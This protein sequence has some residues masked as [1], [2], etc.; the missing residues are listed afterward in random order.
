MLSGI[1]IPPTSAA[2][3]QGLTGVFLMQ[4]LFSPKSHAAHVCFNGFS[5]DVCSLRALTGDC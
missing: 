5:C 2:T 4:V 3:F 1:V